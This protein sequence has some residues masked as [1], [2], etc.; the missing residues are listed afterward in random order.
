MTSGVL[1][2]HGS[3]SFDNAKEVPDDALLKMLQKQEEIFQE[4]GY[5]VASIIP[6]NLK[7]LA[8]NGKEGKGS[9]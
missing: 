4:K 8:N 3:V 2:F 9:K 6:N 5:K 1:A 7:Q